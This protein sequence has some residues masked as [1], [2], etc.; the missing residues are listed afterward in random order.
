MISPVTS[1]DCKQIPSVNFRV[2]KWSCTEE[3][4]ETECLDNRYIATGTSFQTVAIENNV[5]HKFCTNI[6]MNDTI[7]SKWCNS[8]AMKSVSYSKH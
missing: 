5:Y 7:D 8:V 2:L 4:N 3:F 6:S 1:E